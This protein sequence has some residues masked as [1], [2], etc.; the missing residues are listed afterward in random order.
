MNGT[1]LRLASAGACIVALA[2][3]SGALA[4]KHHRA[5][6]TGQPAAPTVVVPHDYDAGGNGASLE[7]PAAGVRVNLFAPIEVATSLGNQA[8]GELGLPPLGL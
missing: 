8:L 1:T 5:H 3:P 6:K 4:K 7:S 2:A